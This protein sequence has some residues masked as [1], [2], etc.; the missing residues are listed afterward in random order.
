MKPYHEGLSSKA[1][2]MRQHHIHYKIFSCDRQSLLGVISQRGPPCTLQ[3]RP[4]SPFQFGQ[5]E[6]IPGHS[7]E[8][9]AY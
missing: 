2:S 3:K 1:R 4:F 5:E 6:I 8:R 7:N 9:R